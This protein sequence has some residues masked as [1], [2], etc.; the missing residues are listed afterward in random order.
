MLADTHAEA[1]G[2]CLELMAAL[3]VDSRQD[4]LLILRIANSHMLMMQCSM[5]CIS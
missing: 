1:K 4:S 2:S 5:L 3:T